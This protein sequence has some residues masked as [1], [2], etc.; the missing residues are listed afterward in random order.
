MIRNSGIDGLI[1]FLKSMTPPDYLV[2]FFAGLAITHF[3]IWRFNKFF[4]SPIDAVSTFKHRLHQISDQV[5]FSLLGIYRV[6][7]GAI[8]V[9]LPPIMLVE[10]TLQNGIYLLV[11]FTLGVSCVA[12]S[13]WLSYWQ[14]K[15][16]AGK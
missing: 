10:P 4:Y 16:G 3:I 7:A 9:A 14:H 5:G 11:C 12:L 6:I 1:S 8:F 13:C 15:T 2:Y